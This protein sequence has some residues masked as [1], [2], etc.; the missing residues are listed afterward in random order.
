MKDFIQFVHEGKQLITEDFWEYNGWLAM[1]DPYK[2]FKRKKNSSKIMW[3]ISQIHH[4]N[5]PARATDRD[6]NLL[7]EEIQKYYLKA[8][9]FKWD[10]YAEIIDA[11][12]NDCLTNLEKQMVS[13]E[14]SLVK[15]FE[16]GESL[17]W[18][19]KRKEK[20][21]VLL[22]HDKFVEKFLDIRSKVEQEKTQTSFRKGKALSLIEGLGDAG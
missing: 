11:F 2:S 9:T 8:K 5:S 6:I 21:D 16:Y 13:W 19:T 18:K 4:P 22:N 3:A 10:D 20:D 7:T 12:K 14:E 17:D 1:L 15:R